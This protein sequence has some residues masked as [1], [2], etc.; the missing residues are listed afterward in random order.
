[1]AAINQVVYRI[2]NQNGKRQVVHVDRLKPSRQQFTSHS[3]SVRPQV[4]SE[5]ADNPPID[6]EPSVVYME[7][8]KLLPPAQPPRYAFRARQNLQTPARYRG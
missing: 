6:Y 5:N 3:V 2:E 4:V 8:G 7:A 1:M